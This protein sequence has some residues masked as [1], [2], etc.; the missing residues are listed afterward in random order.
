MRPSI[1]SVG[2][3]RPRTHIVQNRPSHPFTVIHCNRAAFVA[4]SEGVRPVESCQT[5]LAL[6]IE[7]G[8][9]QARPFVKLLLDDPHA[10]VRQDT[11]TAHPRAPIPIFYIHDL[12]SPFCAHPLCFCQREKNAATRLFRDIAEGDVLIAQL[13]AVAI[14]G[15]DAMSQT[16]GT[17]Q[18]TRTEVHVALLPGIPKQCQLLGHTWQR[19]TREGVKVCSLCRI[20][21]YCPACTAVAPHNAQPFT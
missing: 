15:E 7:R 1:A 10:Y 13:A 21:G 20:R 3:C 11:D 2:Y 12:G 16:T 18:P 19:T 4:R 6:S 17:N 8:D 14:D 5:R 9:M